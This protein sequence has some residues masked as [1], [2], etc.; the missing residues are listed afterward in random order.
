MMVE[1]GHYRMSLSITGTSREDCIAQ[2]QRQFPTSDVLAT[3]ME[4][5]KAVYGCP[6]FTGGLQGAKEYVEKF[7]PKFNY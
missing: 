6:G 3:K 2:I 7:L 5:I 1:K 4:V